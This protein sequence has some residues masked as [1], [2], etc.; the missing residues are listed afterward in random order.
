MP[1][2]KKECMTKYYKI[3]YCSIITVSIAFSVFI[4]LHFWDIPC[5]ELKETYFWL[6]SSLLQGYVAYLPFIG[7]LAIF[8]IQYTKKQNEIWNSL[9]VEKMME[10][11]IDL[12]EGEFEDNL[13]ELLE[14]EKDKWEIKKIEKAR[15]FKN[16]CSKSKRLSWLIYGGFGFVSLITIICTLGL[17]SI[18]TNCQLDIPIFQWYIPIHILFLGLFPLMSASVIIPLELLRWHMEILFN[19]TVVRKFNFIER[20]KSHKV[21][22]NR[23]QT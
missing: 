19:P 1:E 16:I 9:L 20:K 6:F 15:D 18:P 5:N 13:K 12:Q 22:S 8:A 7:V 14:S 23:K 2:E 4:T 10:Y 3:I 17:I 11:N 21:T